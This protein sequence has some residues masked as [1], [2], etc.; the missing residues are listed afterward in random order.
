MPIRWNR[1]NKYGNIHTS[2]GDS[3]L[4]TRRRAELELL[5]RAG[6]IKD[7]RTQ[8][9]FVLIPA[10]YE[11]FPRYS[12]KTGKRIKD[13]QR[14]IE[15]ECSYYADFVYVDNETGKTVVED[16]KG[17]HT[18][19][20]LIKRKLMLYVHKIKIKEITKDG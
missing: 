1:P 10:Q 6:K 20:Y 9:K 4:E 17:F 13:G 12:P 11:S 14:C 5:L 2:R 15:K 19:K 3:I 16:A 8:V 18:E 7:L